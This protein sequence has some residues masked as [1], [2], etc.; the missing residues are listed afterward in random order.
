MEIA[1]VVNLLILA[2]VECEKSEMFLQGL[3]GLSEPT[4]VY[5]A[6]VVEEFKNDNRIR[7][8]EYSEGVC[9]SAILNNSGSTGIEYDRENRQHF[10]DKDRMIDDQNRLIT[11]LQTRLDEYQRRLA[12]HEAEV[13]PIDTYLSN[14]A[15]LEDQ[16]LS[17][18]KRAEKVCQMEI[19]MKKTNDIMQTM[20]ETIQELQSRLQSS[21]TSSKTLPTELDEFLESG[22]I[23]TGRVRDEVILTLKEQL[24]LRD[25]EIAFL[26]DERIKLSDQFGK[27][28]KL[29]VSSIHSIALRY[30]EEMVLTNATNIDS[31]DSPSVSAEHESPSPPYG[32]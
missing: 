13:A 24:A 6:K 31:G 25:E 8:L 16:V 32:G 20:R 30:H 26:R 3:L 1:S 2:Q 22:G 4:K 21:E 19:E 10:A 18:S 29:L 27:T 9:S 5:V 7:Y 17:L 11:T 15:Q 12:A 23:M 28:E 14:I